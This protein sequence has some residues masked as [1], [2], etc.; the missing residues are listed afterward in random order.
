MN[1]QIYRLKIIVVFII[2]FFLSRILID[3]LFIDKTPRLQPNLKEKYEKK[4]ISFFQAI[5]NFGWLK[6]ASGIYA[7]TEGQKD[8]LKIKNEEVEWIE[9]TFVIKNQTIKIKV[10]KGELPPPQELIEKIN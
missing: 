6:L 5:D 8:Y 1:N 10:P 7:K 4:V 3:G 2:S 9:Y